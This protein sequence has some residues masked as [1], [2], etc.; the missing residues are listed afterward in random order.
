MCS[1]SR[2]T[3]SAAFYIVLAE[4]AELSYCQERPGLV[5]LSMGL[6][7]QLCY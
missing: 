2:C 7:G 3:P 6:Q 1:V 5:N 4:T